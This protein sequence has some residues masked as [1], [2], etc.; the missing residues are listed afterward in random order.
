MTNIKIDMKNEKVE[1]AI[2]RQ[3]SQHR[4]RVGENTQYSSE[5]VQNS[6]EILYS[7]ECV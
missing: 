3:I 4:P 2:D 1:Q 6:M 7:G 5:N